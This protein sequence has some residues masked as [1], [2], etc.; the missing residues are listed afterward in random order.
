MDSAYRPAAGARVEVVNGPE[1]GLSTIAGSDGRYGLGGSFDAATEFRATKDGYIT[2]SCVLGT[3][4]ATGEVQGFRFTL[5]LTTP[6]VNVAEDYTL[7]FAAD[8]T[9]TDLPV[10][11]Q[12]RTYS[13]A[14][15]PVPHPSGLASTYF[16]MRFPGGR[17]LEDHASL[18]ILVAGDYV[19]FNVEVALREKLELDTD[20]GVDGFASTSVGPALSNI[21]IPFQGAFEYCKRRSVSAASPG[22]APEGKL[23]CASNNHRLILVRR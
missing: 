8:S 3:T 1:A 7:T 11:A 16:K 19:A 15:S 18:D 22:C 21:S 10:E 4:D 17:L 9:C 2:N 12:T 13:A 5:D 23:R 6:P 20:F 14:I